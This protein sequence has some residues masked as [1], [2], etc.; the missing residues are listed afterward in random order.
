MSHPEDFFK[1]IYYDEIDDF[2]NYLLKQIKNTKVIHFKGLPSNTDLIGFYS[3]LVDRIGKA[4]NVGEDAVTGNQTNERW[5]DVKYVQNLD[6]TFRHSNT[7]QPLHTDAAYTNV[8]FDI[9]FFFALESAKVG[10]ATVFIDGLYL[11]EILKEFEADLYDTLINTEV[12]FQKSNEQPKVSKIISLTENGYNINWNYFRVSPD[13]SK[14]IKSLCVNFHHFLEN[15]I[16]AGGQTQEV[17]LK[18]GECLFFQDNQVLH[19]RNS[20]Y[21]NRHLIKG[22]FNFD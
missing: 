9:N 7:R 8:N 18:K 19:G 5:T 10:G 4:V 17:N 22:S 14:K 1:T 3:A 11:I 21:G 6:N 15:K 13:N 2:E 20:F 12:I 16:V